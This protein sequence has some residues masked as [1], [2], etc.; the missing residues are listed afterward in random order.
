VNDPADVVVTNQW[1]E[2]SIT[3]AIKQ[4]HHTLPQTYYLY[5]F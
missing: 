5:D 3:L 2:R 4:N 1:I